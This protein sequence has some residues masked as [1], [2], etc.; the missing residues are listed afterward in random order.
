MT[1]GLRPAW[2]PTSL[3]ALAIAFVW[4]TEDLYD[5][6]YV[7]THTQGFD[8]W[9][10]YVLGESDGVPKTPEWA[11]EETLIPAREIRALAREWGSEEDH[12]RR[13]RHGRLGR[14][15]PLR[16]MAPSMPAP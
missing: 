7:A 2:A 15:L 1:S 13:R 16:P 12:A 8:E 6:D 9:K 5:K 4:L 14:R 10:R 11:D 3:L